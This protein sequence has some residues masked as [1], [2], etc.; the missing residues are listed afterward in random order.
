[1]MNAELDLRERTTAY[2]LRI[3]KLVGTVEQFGAASVIARQLVRSGTSIGAQYREACRARSPAK[4]ISKMESTCQEIDESSYWLELLARS[5]MITPKRLDALH[6][7]T[8][9][10]MAIFV[11]SVK[12]AKRSKSRND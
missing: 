7:E 2:A 11:T 8:D 1:M 6:K 5:G 9:E 4:F 3:I 12:T 10:L